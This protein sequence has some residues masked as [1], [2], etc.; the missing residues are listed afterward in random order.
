MP[1]YT[2]LSDEPTGF[3]VK[4]TAVGENMPSEIFVFHAIAGVGMHAFTNV[5]ALYELADLTTLSYAIVDG[6]ISA[7][8]YRAN[9]VNLVLPS[10]DKVAEVWQ[11][12][13]ADVRRLVKDY[14]NA[15]VM[16]E[17]ETVIINES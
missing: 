8:Y 14:N 12:I 17:T 3:P 16:S 10:V 1:D 4:I 2:Q 5:A 6:E 9:E 15:N 7:P 11:E 13:Q